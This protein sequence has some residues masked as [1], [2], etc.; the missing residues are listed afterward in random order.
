MRSS[1]AADDGLNWCAAHTP[2]L[3]LSGFCWFAQDRLYRR[4]PVAP[5]Q[6]LPDAVD[7]L[8]NHTA[9]GQ[10]RWRSNSRRIAVRVELAG[11]AGMNHMPATGQCGFDLYVGPAGAEVFA[12]IT[13]YDI[14]QTHYEI[15][16]LHQPAGTWR[17]L[18]LN[19]PLYQGVR[20]VEVGLDPD[21]L[22]EAPAPRAPDPIVFYGTS[23]TQGGCAARPGM[24]FPAILSRRLQYPC[25]NLGFSGNGRGQPEVAHAIADIA[26]CSLF[27]LD[28]DA[29]CPDAA[30]LARTLPAF[31]DILRARHPTTP[32]LVVSRIPTGSEAWNPGAIT[33]RQERA[34]AQEQVVEQRSVGG[35]Q[36]LHFLDGSKLLGGADFHECTV[37]GSHP[38]DLGFL[39]I[40]DGLEPVLQ[41]IL[42]G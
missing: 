4:M 29:N 20:S 19:F 11:P 28:Y 39:R 32:I 17:D 15:Q 12:G 42:Q 41:A 33:Q 31:I 27:V 26:S 35:E 30:H 38:T 10:I 23:I 6:V 5:Q 8:A 40:A 7:S 36:G 24:A 9:G 34:R 13:K 25:V 21:A 16:L 37:D 18:T 2:P 1:A 14:K 22:I 3:E